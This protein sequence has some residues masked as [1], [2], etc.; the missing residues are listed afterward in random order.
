MIFDLDTHD[1]ECRL[2]ANGANV[3]VVSV[4]YRL[5]PEHPFP[6]AFEDCLAATHWAVEQKD[7]LGANG[8]GLAVGGDSAGGEPC[9]SSERGVAPVREPGR[10]VP[11]ADLPS[12]R[13]L[14]SGGLL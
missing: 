12:D 4:D 8:G 2:L 6:A 1:R 5:A 3:I 11:D 13:S 10:A 14:A 9:C 7:A